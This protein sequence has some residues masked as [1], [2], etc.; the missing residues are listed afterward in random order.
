MIPPL[1][2][3]EPTALEASNQTSPDKLIELHI[4]SAWPIVGNTVIC[5]LIAVFALCRALYALRYP[6][7][8]PSSLGL[9]ALATRV[10]GAQRVDAWLQETRQLHTAHGSFAL[11]RH[12]SSSL[13][14]LPEKQLFGHEWRGRAEQSVLWRT[15]PATK[16]KNKLRA[17]A[18][19]LVSPAAQ[20]SALRI[21]IQ[22]L[23]YLVPFMCIIAIFD[24]LLGFLYGLPVYIALGEMH[25]AFLR[26]LEEHLR[27]ATRIELVLDAVHRSTDSDDAS[28]NA[29]AAYYQML[30]NY[31]SSDSTNGTITADLLRCELQLLPQTDDTDFCTSSSAL[32]SPTVE[33][34]ADQTLAESGRPAEDPSYAPEPCMSLHPRLYV[35]PLRARGHPTAC[36][37]RVAAAHCSR[38]Y[39]WSPCVTLWTLWKIPTFNSRRSATCRRSRMASG[40]LLAK[41]S[42]VMGTSTLR[43]RTSSAATRIRS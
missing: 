37:V 18:R 25:G 32:H 19:C 23:S 3:L 7:T 9:R 26:P 35:R 14:L 24:G 27:D 21:L 10:W 43:S 2:P 42:F 5:G 6:A 13:A 16:A 29:T 33:A 8:N 31:Y 38:A 41:P 34:I 17:A 22:F 30:A 40:T 11:W 1:P 20:S 4:L 36:S 15:Q 28:S 12:L 39:S